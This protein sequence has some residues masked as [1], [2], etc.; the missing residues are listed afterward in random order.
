MVEQYW[1]D[2]K[3]NEE[4]EDMYSDAAVARFAKSEEELLDLE[5]E[6]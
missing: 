2:K 4:R 1:Q 5:D 6:E 3:A